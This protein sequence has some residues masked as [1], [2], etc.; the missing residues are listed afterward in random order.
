MTTT[1]IHTIRIGPLQISWAWSS[2]RC[3]RAFTTR[4]LQRRNFPRI[5]RITTAQFHQIGVDKP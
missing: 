5:D 4:K 2:D 3:L 1:P